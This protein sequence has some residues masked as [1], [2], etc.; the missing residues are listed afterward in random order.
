M[1]SDHMSGVQR[2]CN[3]ESVFTTKSD[4]I[5]QIF[6]KNQII[7]KLFKHFICNRVHYGK[8]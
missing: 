8:D 3:H 6:R 2:V 5:L 7:K 4:K 1:F